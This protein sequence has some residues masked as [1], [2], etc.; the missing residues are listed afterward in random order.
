MTV[1]GER[2][3]KK[4]GL[5]I[6]LILMPLALMAE[7][8]CAVVKI[9]IRQE[10]S[11]ERQAFDAK[12][13]VTN[14]LDLVDLDNIDIDVIFEDKDGNP[15]L[16][17]SD[18]NNTNASFFITVD[19]M[20]GID[21][22]DGS[23]VI[24]AGNSAE[25]HWLIVPASGAGGVTALGERYAVGARVSYTYG[26]ES[27]LIN[28]APDFIQVKPTPILALDYFIPKDVFGDDPLTPGVE[29][30]EPFDLG[31]RISNSG[32]GDAVNLRVESAQPKII[33]NNQ[34]L[35]IDFTLL[36]S[37]INDSEVNNSLLADVGSLSSGES[38]MVSWLMS[39]SLNGEF[40]SF[41]ADFVHSDALGGA[42]TSLV[43]SVST[44]FLAHK[45]LVDLPGRDAIS[46]F[47]AKDGDQYRVYESSGG[48]GD[49]IEQSAVLSNGGVIVGKQHYALSFSPTA[50]S[51]YVQVEDPYQG[52][53][54]EIT[55]LRSDGKMLPEQNVWQ[56]KIESNPGEYSYYIGLFDVDSTGQYDIVINGAE[57]NVAPEIHV[58]SPQSG[59]VNVALEFDIEVTDANSSDQVSLVL[60]TGPSE[61]SVSFVSNSTWRFSWVPRAVGTQQI[62]L[63]AS[64]TQEITDA[65]VDIE[66][67]LG[68]QNDTDGDG[69]LDEWEQ[70]YFGSLD[71]DGAGDFDQDSANNKEEHDFGGDPTLE[72][73]PGEVVIVNSMN[74]T[75]VVNE[76]VD[77]T[78]SNASGAVDAN[79]VYQFELFGS[80]LTATPIARAE[81]AES[82][83]QT[84]WSHGLILTED[85]FYQW[86]VRAFDGVTPGL[87]SY[88][89]FVF[90]AS[91]DAP[92]G[93]L[94]SAP[95]HAV[96]I[97][98]SRPLLQVFSATDKDSEEIS[99]RFTLYADSG[100]SQ[101]V[102]QS[103]WLPSQKGAFQT[104]EPYD[105]LDSGQSYYWKTEVTDGVNS[106]SCGVSQF[107]VDESVEV[108]TGYQITAPVY[109]G[110]I[111]GTNVSL[112][113]SQSN[114][115]VG[116]ENY[117][118]VYQLSTSP[119]YDDVALIESNELALDS[120]GIS[121]FDVAGL[122]VNTLYYWR[123][124]AVTDTQEGSW[125]YGRFTVLDPTVESYLK[126]LNPSAMGWVSTREP[127]LYMAQSGLIQSVNQ[128]RVELYGDADATDLLASH[129]TTNSQLVLS[130]LTDRTSYYW[131]FKVLLDNGLETDF[132]SL[133]SFFVIDDQI[134][135]P[136]HFEFVSL[137]SPG[138]VGNKS[139]DILWKDG[140]NDSNAS[141]SL[142]YDTDN[143]GN[144]GIPIIEGLSENDALDLH[145]WRLE[146]VPEGEYYLYA[147]ISDEDSSTTVY[148]DYTLMVKHVD[149]D[150][151]TSGRHTSEN[152]DSISITVTLS[153]PPIDYIVIPLSVGDTGEARV[154]DNQL[155]FTNRN[156]STPQVFSVIGVDDQILDGEQIYSLLFGAVISTDP[157]YSGLR[158]NPIELVNHDNE[159]NS[160]A[161]KNALIDLYNQTNGSEWTNSN[162][163]LQGEP[164]VDAWQGVI[165]DSNNEA[166]ITLDLS[167]NHLKG[168]LPS[169]LKQLSQLKNL[170]LNNNEL[171]GSIPV[172]LAELFELQRLHLNNN[173][174]KGEIP[175]EL[176]QLI[177][178][179][180][181]D[182]S[183]N[184]LTGNIPSELGRLNQLKI[185]SLASNFLSGNIP[186]TFNQL[187]LLEVLYLNDNVL[188]GSLNTDFASLVNLKR[189]RL[190]NNALM[191]S[192][193]TLYGNLFDLVELDMANND[194]TG[195]L[196]ASWRTM[197]ALETL[198]LSG[199]QLEGQM[200]ASWEEM[201]SLSVLILNNNQ[202]SGA[203]PEEL[204]VLAKLTKLYVNNNNLSGEIPAT[205]G[206]LVALKRLRLQN[207][208]LTG[209]IP[210]SFGGLQSLLELNLSHN[211][212]IG[213]IPQNLSGLA[214]LQ[215]LLA[216]DNQL[217]GE[218]PRTFSQL[219]KLVNLKLHDNQIT[220]TIPNA[221]GG[222]TS[223]TNLYL[224]RNRLNG[225]IPQTLANLP[226][227]AR[228]KLQ[229][230]QLQGQPPESLSNL[231]DT[232][233]VDGL[234]IR[235]NRLM[236]V[237]SV[238]DKFID[239]FHKGRDWS[240]TQTVPSVDLVVQSI[241]PDSVTLLWKPIEYTFDEGYFNVYVSLAGHEQY[242]LVG[243]SK[244]K[245]STKFL[246]SGLDT[247]NNSYDFK[248]NTETK[249]HKNNP[250]VLTSQ[251]SKVVTSGQ[252]TLSNTYVALKA[253]YDQTNGSS[254]IRKSNWLEGTPC[255]NSW[256]GVICDTLNENVIGL[257]LDSNGL[258]GSLP[259]ELSILSSLEHLNL[260]NN[261]LNGALPSSWK[262]LVGLKFLDISKN[263]LNGSLP[264]FIGQ[265][266]KLQLLNL[267]NNQLTGYLPDS[268]GDLRQLR[269]LDL[270]NNNL[271]GDIPFA[272]SDLN[273]LKRLD[274]GYN[275]LTG[276]VPNAFSS[277]LNLEYLLLN[278]NELS[279]HLPVELSNLNKLI[280][281]NFSYNQIVGDLPSDYASLL[282]LRLLKL[283][284]NLLTGSIPAEWGRM[285]LLTNMNLSGNK[286]EGEIPL[287]LGGLVSLTSLSLSD[288]LLSGTLPKSTVT[289][290]ALINL[291]LNDNLLEGSIPVELIQK[292]TLRRLRLQNNN[293]SG[294][295]PNRFSIVPSLLEI[296][297]ANNELS[298]SLP[299]DWSEMSQLQTLDLS[300]NQLTGL[301]P[302]EW[303]SM[304]SLVNLALNNN[305]LTGSI[306][307]EFESLQALKNLYLNNNQ[308]SGSL[309]DSLANATELVK[310]K[311]Q[312]NNLTGGLPAR[313]GELSNLTKINLSN[314]D[315]SGELPPEWG[316]LLSINVINLANNTIGGTIPV[317]W[318][319]LTKLVSL[320][321]N[322]NK[323]SGQI[324]SQ[325]TKM[326]ALENLD[327]A[328][329]KFSGEIP[330]ALGELKSLKR[331]RLQENQLTGQLPN[332]I[333]DLARLMELNLSDNQ[334]SGLIPN[335][336]DQLIALET[337]YL[338]NN[339]LSGQI[340]TSIGRMS[341]LKRLKLDGNSLEGSPP[342]SLIQLSDTLV[343]NGLDLR[344]NR[345]STT[346]IIVDRQLDTIQKGGN[347]SGTQTVPPLALRVERVN[348][349]SFKVSWQTIEY[350]DDE[351]YYEIYLSLLGTNTYQLF[352]KTE[353]KRT[354]EFIVK[355]IAPSD[356]YEV[357][358]RTMT[359][360][361]H[362]NK[363]QL[364]SI[365]SDVVSTPSL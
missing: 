144:N 99:Y 6:L 253:L 165:C 349:D 173:V 67:S 298:G 58:V 307:N 88:D 153:E 71:E 277:L 115:V 155:V 348:E 4:I 132:S 223:L 117:R 362:N 338:S 303:S 17:S 53:K 97:S 252:N 315:L 250:N 98:D 257:S 48:Q 327:L 66:V 14:G 138:S 23:G 102:M 333:S 332:S 146:N 172:S 216:Y 299:T 292:T 237:E 29:A 26:E 259:S 274:L 142:Y 120:D 69:L 320:S 341:K 201:R 145:S 126:A 254:W 50:G 265:L 134:N 13:L 127:T 57:P 175:A 123:A 10:L 91:D 235:F 170:Y 158:I 276:G 293:F 162:Q 205:L 236:P 20:Q 244:N 109:D 280:Q 119:A 364:I 79:M 92:Q 100:L 286:L 83:V 33:E 188:S 323:I 200:P 309:P 283:D 62:V 183:S 89:S 209:E 207:N 36:G 359:E 76:P 95:S 46:D 229:G 336:F 80:D 219:T 306:P 282:S 168:K 96:V 11:F 243:S 177:H 22:I 125:V 133:K 345:L 297:L 269:F 208:S 339:K 78:V 262:N 35:L 44:H 61:A 322:N 43:Q 272:L 242:R 312:N 275:N 103:A 16:A 116:Y 296:N 182:L 316:G 324:P 239:N 308:L 212:L 278:N 335:E 19:S 256:Y 189:M 24:D 247:I 51:A 258:S 184:A 31:L 213:E 196:P 55:A 45:V 156:W 27:Q 234:D 281:L 305:R 217:S 233:A 81:V 331:L 263:H 72:D 192:L 185:L 230:N 93:C 285:N 354:D 52:Q 218:L 148:S 241:T 110:L 313:Y 304:L 287:E 251:Y 114:Q 129:N 30:V 47:L 9:E 8:I 87:W 260:K 232:L 5:L 220:G 176:G 112:A 222:M 227:L 318:E 84:I 18:P 74:G 108:L 329:N 221:W 40:I 159:I 75:V 86:R 210:T 302:V 101:E 203:I 352:G 38:V 113:I 90:S 267:G 54:Q 49:V 41:E 85:Q 356:V 136:P 2:A 157:K 7:T 181:L 130:D 289:L 34:G 206:E 319:G 124:K 122:A 107:V 77:L 273:Q 154:S 351:G 245:S 249:A 37:Q 226:I 174:F 64:D 246:V 118:F 266:S 68:N 310:I 300:G 268:L 1:Y 270:S 198:N 59:V 166:V 199:N 328:D 167:N 135:E 63:R 105:D 361:H 334:I 12:M 321:L 121:H 195:L 15:V 28:V 294:V 224:H 42:L 190:Q 340:P 330:Q 141:I 197:T 353:N 147:T 255:A 291:Y 143:V 21:D 248:I 288:N 186:V 140:D 180:E 314:N 128:Y 358:I 39:T 111:N 342:E 149:I 360:A 151:E 290:P 191:G 326:G 295:L 231:A 73:R 365:F 169:T 202:L 357:K 3:M 317:Q 211:N 311:I 137:R 178:L 152:G 337:L 56:F 60:L 171:S 271:V 193:P 161:Q 164:C 344:F 355:N 261:S 350:V 264:S 163:W 160:E 284:N 204:G 228:L 214:E 106:T 225:E 325:L 25:I 194:L 279:G 150:I 343:S 238:L 70:R 240:M 347:W 187:T 215:S 363:N 104:W 32:H 346:S 301:I 131:R 179:I 65:V 94:L 82:E 139:Y